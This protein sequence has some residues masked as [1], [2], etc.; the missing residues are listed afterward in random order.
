[1]VILQVPLELAVP[2]CSLTNKISV[3]SVD[4]EALG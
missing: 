4:K 3:D 1:M 2:G